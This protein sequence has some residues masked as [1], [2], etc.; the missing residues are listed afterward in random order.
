MAYFGEHLTYDGYGGDYGAL[1]CRATVVQALN[2]LVTALGMTLLGGPDVYRA[3]ANDKKDPGGWTGMVVL[4]E[5]HISI[6]TFPARGFISADVYTCKNGLDVDAIRQF[7]RA[8]FKI[9]D[10]EI[11]FIKRGTRYPRQNIHQPGDA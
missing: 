10:E 6:H 9:A 2:D 4:Q 5:S 3:S 8:R 1:D 11:N 7:F